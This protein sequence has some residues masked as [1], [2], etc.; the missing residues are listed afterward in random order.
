MEL[1]G[2]ALFNLL[3]ISLQEKD[4]KAVGEWRVED[5]K[6][7]T[8]EE[9]LSRLKQMGLILDEPSFYL[10]TESYETPEALTD[11]LCVEEESPERYDQIYLIVFE[12][13]RRLVKE[14]FCLSIFCDELDHWIELYDKGDLTDELSLRKALNLL[15]DILDES[16][17]APEQLLKEVASYCA[18]DLEQFLV[19][20]ISDQIQKGHTT[21]ASELID[22]FYD[23]ASDP[24]QFHLLRA[25]LV[26]YSD[27]ERG[28]VLYERVLEELSDKPD[29]ELAL[30][31]VEHLI[32]HGHLH[33]FIKAALLAMSAITIEEEF[34]ILLILVAEYYRCQDK[35]QEEA[36][37]QKILNA[38]THLNLSRAVTPSD[39]DL[40]A[41][42][43]LLGSGT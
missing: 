37:V 19:D 4:P 40:V 23:Y 26:A 36:Q 11:C 16:E 28:N 10:Y 2:K 13:W 9:L 6:K 24:R 17:G 1:K 32:H 20:Y 33:L 38:R 8:I 7:C 18:H 21:Y 43:L 12:L 34:Q 27:L 31:V 3:K 15:E 41:I 39:P 22:A 14:K 5:L 35:E 25:S 42:A 29:L 30:N